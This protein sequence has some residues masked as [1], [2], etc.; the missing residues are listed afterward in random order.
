MPGPLAL[1]IDWGWGDGSVSSNAGLPENERAVRREGFNQEAEDY[2]AGRP[3]YPERVYDLLREVCGL[4]PKTRVLEIGAGSGQA[5]GRLLD[6]G[7]TV[8]AVELG[9][10]LADLLRANYDD[11]R[12]A[13]KVG[14]F[15]DLDLPD[16]LF[17]LVASAT[18]FHWIPT[19][20]GLQKVARCLA[21]S[22][23][24][25]LWWTVFGDPSRADPFH[26]ALQPILQR[27]APEL[28]HAKSAANPGTTSEPPYALDVDAR[29]A[30]FNAAGGF[31]PVYFERIEW[32]GRHT[33]T[34]I[35]AM[36]ASFSPWIALAP[37]H[38]GR[39]L[40]EVERLA[41]DEFGG[42]VERPY[43]TPVYVASAE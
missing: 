38:R 35:R 39:V 10:N 19:V 11:A 34:S 17:D 33:A 40:D 36:F 6:L 7:G 5:T 21:P 18:A 30:D 9:V 26:E 24:V 22:G 27:V 20:I 16:G 8:T 32:T 43:V 25:A 23:H 37:D 4:S 1:T 3:D 41:N 14:A 15:E 12:L 2:D 13:V 29:V 31:G 42:V 28:L